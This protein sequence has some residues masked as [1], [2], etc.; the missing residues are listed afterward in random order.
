LAGS[1]QASA[2]TACPILV[3]WLDATVSRD[4]PVPGSPEIKRLS[5]EAGRN[6]AQALIAPAMPLR[7]RKVCCNTFTLVPSAIFQIE[8]LSQGAGR[9]YFEKAIGEE[10]AD[11]LS[12]GDRAF[13][14]HGSAAT[15]RR[16][17]CLLDSTTRIL[18]CSIGS[19]RR[20]AVRAAAITPAADPASARH[21][22]SSSLCRPIRLRGD[23]PAHAPAAVG[24]QAPAGRPCMAHSPP[25]PISTRYPV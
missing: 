3:Y 11:G 13:A 8:M 18:P 16:R 6:A 9:L 14:G 15:A 5:T 24:F 22:P 2:E 12:L 20:V 19:P 4:L 1:D 7:F 23:A 10:Q 21:K 17:P 25:C